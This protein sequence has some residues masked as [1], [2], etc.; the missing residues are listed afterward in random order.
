[1]MRQSESVWNSLVLSALL[2]TTS[3]LGG[4]DDETTDAELGGPS[5]AES[6]SSDSPT[7]G[8]GSERGT[9]PTQANDR[10]TSAVTQSVYSSGADGSVGSND[11][12]GSH[13][14]VDN[15]TEGAGLGSSRQAADAGADPDVAGGLPPCP[16]GLREVFVA[17]QDACPDEGF[18][19]QVAMTCTGGPKPLVLA[20]K[21]GSWQQGPRGCD[22]PYEYCHE[23][24]VDATGG[25]F[26]EP[27]VTCEDGVWE[28]EFWT[29][30]LGDGIIDCPSEPPPDEGECYG[31]G[32]GGGYWE[33]C[34][35][36]CPGEGERWT[37]ASCALVE[38]PTPSQPAG[39]WTYDGA[40]D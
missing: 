27:P 23:A 15:E 36:P 9:S 19:C 24:S 18:E 26:T 13:E 7:T 8:M 30:G 4:C 25:A 10:A 33:Y 14:G 34:G 6:P 38:S 16:V 35:Y 32:T 11:S 31:G 2:G 12:R 17:G 37:I 29:V 40:C 21:D 22:H 5:G 28:I 3:V 39:Y 20:C 1:M